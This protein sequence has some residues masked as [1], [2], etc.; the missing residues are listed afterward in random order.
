MIDEIPKCNCHDIEMYWHKDKTRKNGGRWRCKI[1]R[2]KQDKRWRKTPRGKASIRK[3]MKSEKSKERS[4]RY[5]LSEKGK[6][7]RRKAG[8]IYDN[9]PHGYIKRRERRLLKSKEENL[10]KLN[11]IKKQLKELELV[12]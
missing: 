3:Y 5:Y 12:S 11:E 4:K 10:N 2:S 9:S 8:K 7:T 1:A 6:Q